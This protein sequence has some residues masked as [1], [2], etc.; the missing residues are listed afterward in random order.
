MGAIILISNSAN[1][2]KSSILV[3]LANLILDKY[4]DIQT[5]YTYKHKTTIDFTLVIKVKGKIV[6]FESK[7]TTLNPLENRLEKI[8]ADYNPDLIFCT[9]K[10]KGASLNTVNQIA[11][12]FNYNC[13][14][15]ST[16]QVAND[17]EKANQTKAKHLFY[18][19][20]Q[21]DLF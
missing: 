5:I 4:V 8:I 10:T 3:E 21:L 9:S 16:Y 6:A 13:I 14:K 15:T 11:S 20:I 12:K 17:F 19:A 2:G 1:K 7:S 18:L